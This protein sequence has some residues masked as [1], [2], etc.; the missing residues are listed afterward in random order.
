MI[1]QVKVTTESNFYCLTTETRLVYH[2]SLKSF[3]QVVQEKDSQTY[4]DFQ[5]YLQIQLIDSAVRVIRD[6]IIKDGSFRFCEWVN[7]L[8]QKIEKKI[9]F[10][11]L[12]RLYNKES[13]PFFINP[14]VA[15][16]AV[17][18]PLRMGRGRSIPR[19]CSAASS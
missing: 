19:G 16:V 6:A 11:N 4:S 18:H 5:I 2:M 13:C 7:I 1:P 14:H 9:S 8:R 15:A 17:E 10:C 12:P 3:I